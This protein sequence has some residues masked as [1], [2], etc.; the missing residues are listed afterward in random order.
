LIG[1]P[2]GCGQRRGLI[3]QGGRADQHGELITTVPQPHQRDQQ[4][5]GLRHPAITMTPQE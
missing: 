2:D 4:V 1:L 3:R 5:Q